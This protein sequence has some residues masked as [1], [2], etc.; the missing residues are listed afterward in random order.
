MTFKEEQKGFM[1]SVH[2]AA[3]TLFACVT[4][5]AHDFGVTEIARVTGLHRAT[6]HRFLQAF[7]AEGV[8]EHIK[9]DGEYGVYRLPQGSFLTQPHARIYA[10]NML[11]QCKREEKTA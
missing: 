6:Q 3:L 11:E 5:G 8:I 2:R 1:P 7:A 10:Y 4:L 9:E